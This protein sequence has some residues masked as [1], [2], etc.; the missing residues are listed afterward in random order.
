MKC[1]YCDNEYK[2]V[3]QHEKYC[4]LNP[5]HRLMWNTGLTN[6]TDKHVAEN[7][8]NSGIAIQISY[9]RKNPLLEYKV[10][11]YNCGKEFKIK[12]RQDKFNINKKYFCCKDCS[13]SYVGKLT[14][15]NTKEAKCITCGKTITIPSRASSKIC[16]CI[17]C[18][19]NYIKEKKLKHR[20]ERL[21]NGCE[22]HYGR[23]YSKESWNALHNAG[24]KGIKHQND[25][26][27]SKNEIEFCN[28]CKEY[29]DNVKHNE[30]IFNGWDADVIIEDIKYAVLWNGPWH[31]KQITKSHSVAQTQNRDKIKI[32]EIQKYGWTPYIIKDMGKYNKNFVKEKFDEFLNFLKENSIIK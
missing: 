10:N 2:N 5:T 7:S 23:I 31:Y 19:K 4:K 15:G 25:L 24:C 14:T 13:H 11:C 28:L 29:F 20:L 32:K 22:I 3:R 21:Q 18:K 1:Q 9:Q 17:E 30:C 16:K 8:K 6:E 12:E 27:R 26:R